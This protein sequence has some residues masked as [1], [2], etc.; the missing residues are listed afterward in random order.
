MI[1]DV[2][3]AVCLPALQLVTRQECYKSYFS[4]SYLLDDFGRMKSAFFTHDEVFLLLNF[5]SDVQENFILGSRGY[6]VFFCSGKEQTPT[7]GWKGD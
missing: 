5:W 3:W 1:L 2:L 7:H 6:S 4:L